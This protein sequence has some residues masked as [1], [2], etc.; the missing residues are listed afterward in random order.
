MTPALPDTKYIITERDLR[1]LIAARYME[2]TDVNEAGD[3]EIHNLIAP[4]LKRVRASHS[5]PTNAELVLEDLV[6]RDDVRSAPNDIRIPLQQK[7]EAAMWLFRELSEHR[8]AKE[9]ER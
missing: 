2:N 3:D 7:L 5:S 9:R 1:D 4:V 6:N 8:Q